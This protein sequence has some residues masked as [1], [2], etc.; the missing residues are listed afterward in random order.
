MAAASLQ[1]ASTVLTQIE[2][3]KE[4]LNLLCKAVWSHHLEILSK[5]TRAEERFFNLGLTF[6]PSES[7]QSHVPGCGPGVYDK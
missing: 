3:E 7:H 1:I 5:T 2:K 6:F 4:L